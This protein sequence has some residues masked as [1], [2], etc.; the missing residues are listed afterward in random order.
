MIYLK[1]LSYCVSGSVILTALSSLTYKLGGE[2]L[3]VPG[4]FVE[5]MLTGFIL[6]VF[7]TGDEYF[8]FPSGTYLIFNVIIYSCAAIGL[9]ILAKQFKTCG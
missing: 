8:S 6:L 3:L 1:Y 5:V 4:L 9:L 2:L 7:L